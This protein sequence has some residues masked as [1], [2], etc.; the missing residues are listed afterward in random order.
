MDRQMGHDDGSVQ[1]RYEHVTAGMVDRLLEGLTGLWASALV[2]RRQISAGSPVAA[3]DR[4]LR[5]EAGG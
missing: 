5:Q 1:A 3:L 2:A 4:L